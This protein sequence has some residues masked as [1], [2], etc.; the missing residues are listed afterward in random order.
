MSTSFRDSHD[1]E[2]LTILSLLN[3]LFNSSIFDGNTL[4]TVMEKDLI[5]GRLLDFMKCCII[6]KSLHKS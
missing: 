3:D 1:L 4:I 2:S 5:C 6:F